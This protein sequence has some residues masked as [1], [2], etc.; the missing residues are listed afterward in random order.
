MTKPVSPSC[1][2]RSS[3][4]EDPGLTQRG[5]RKLLY[6]GGAIG[7]VSLLGAFGLKRSFRLPRRLPPVPEELT[8]QAVISGIPGARY[9]V[10]V[11]MEP[12]VR[13]VITARQRETEFLVQSG[14][15]GPLP[16]A[17][18]LAISGGGD[19]GAFGAGLLCGWSAAGNRPRFKCVT[20]I[21]T[22]ALIAPLAFL[23]SEYDE[24]LRKIYT[25]VTLA[26]IAEKRSILAAINNDGMADN[27]PLAGLISK[28]IV[29]TMLSRIAKEHQN[30]RILLILTTN[31]DAREPV[32]WKHGKGRGQRPSQGARALL[33][34]SPGIG[35]NPW[36]LSALDD[37]RRGVRQAVRRDARGWGSVCAGLPL[38]AV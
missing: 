26:D 6:W 5:M 3:D 4:L 15:S 29:Q 27:R 21:S 31:L 36:G 19:K 8:H 28:S 35:C 17:D 11:D 37:P 18:L 12:F 30:G 32:I 16:P 10:G 9:L 38:S 22:G 1:A 2:P 13:D 23:G 34:H 25:S 33:V 14:H 7:A 20:G 24:L